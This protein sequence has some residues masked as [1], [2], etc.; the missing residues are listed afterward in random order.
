[1]LGR[2]RDALAIQRQ[3]QQD[4]VGMHQHGGDGEAA[5]GAAGFIPGQHLRAGQDLANR[6]RPVGGGH[7]CVGGEATAL[8]RRRRRV[9]ALRDRRHHVVGMFE[10]RH[11]L[12][13]VLHR[14]LADAGGLPADRGHRRQ[15]ECRLAIV[16]ARGRDAGVDQIECLSKDVGNGCNRLARS[17]HARQ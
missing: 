16:A 1:M 5:G 13:T 7:Q 15:R 14:Q 3:V 6:N 10:H 2:G 8:D 4:G 12:V 11:G 9:P 17:H